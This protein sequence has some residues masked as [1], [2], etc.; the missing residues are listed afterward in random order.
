MKKSR[1]K[2]I[3]ASILFS[4]ATGIIYVINRLIFGTAVLKEMLKSTANNYYNWRFGKIYYKKIGTGT[5]VLLVHDLTVYSSAYEWNKIVDKLAENHTVYTI[6]LLGCG[7]SDKQRITYTN[8]LYVQIISDFIKNVIH[9][10]TDVITSGY[11][12]SFALMA[13]HNETDLFGKIV[14]INPPALNTLNKI[15]DKKSKLY[16]FLLEIPVFGTLVYNMIT[17]QSNIQLLFT[18]QYLYNPFNMTAEWLDT[19]Y[20]AAHK[21]M[22]SSRYLLSSIIGRYTNN[23]INH[24]LKAIDQSIFIIEGEAERDS[25]DII[26]QYTECNPAV[27]AISLKGAKHLPQM[28]TPDKLMEQLNIFLD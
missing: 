6:D 26:S 5:P 16:K 12:G 2:I 14:M 17:C 9:E 23:N 25:K 1:H 18:E 10:R 21:G 4:I 7:R 15:P 27:E 24:A 11:S 19:Y 8:Y 28:E 13:C 20:E 3:T 22:S